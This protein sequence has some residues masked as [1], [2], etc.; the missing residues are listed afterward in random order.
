MM[1]LM[2][3]CLRYNS[4]IARFAKYIYENHAKMRLLAQ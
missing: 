3:A 2:L 4:I 1:P